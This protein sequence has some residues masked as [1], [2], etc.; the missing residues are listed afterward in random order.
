MSGVV[1]CWTRLNS[2]S[3]IVRFK[4]GW[5]AIFPRLA[6]LSGRVSLKNAVVDEEHVEERIEQHVEHVRQD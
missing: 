1:V 4:C 5:L 2:V 3:D 6:R